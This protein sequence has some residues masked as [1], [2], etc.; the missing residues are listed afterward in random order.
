MRRGQG[1]RKTYLGQLRECLG[2]D[3]NAEL[4]EIADLS[5]AVE[6]NKW[7]GA[8]R[9]GI[10]GVFETRA[11]LLEMP[12]ISSALLKAALRRLFSSCLGAPQR[13]LAPPHKY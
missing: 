4:R 6:F 3:N 13:I 7:S 10:S 12:F 1:N 11:N 5:T 2:I 9:V 8:P